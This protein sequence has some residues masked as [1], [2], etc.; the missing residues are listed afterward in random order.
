[1]TATTGVLFVCRAN[2]CRSPVAA[3]LFRRHLGDAPVSIASAG[4]DAREIT[5]LDDAL[6][7]F[8]AAGIDLTGHRPVPLTADAVRRADLVIGMERAIVRAAVVLD[9]DAWPRAFTLKELV[10]RAGAVGKRADEPVE[11]W[12]ARMHDGRV[13]SDMQGDDRDA[14][15]EDPYAGPRRG[16]AR[17]VNELD[18]LTGEL[19]RLG[20]GA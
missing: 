10:R 13:L 7:S 15:V 20:W 8:A 9:S 5:V 16:Y 1:V 6:V 4:I 3:E 18:A 19:A 17:L 12:V 14:D 11:R 2:V